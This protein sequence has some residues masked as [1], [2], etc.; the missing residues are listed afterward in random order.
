LRKYQE[1]IK[2]A[3]HLPTFSSEYFFVMTI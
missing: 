1:W 2:L 3:Q